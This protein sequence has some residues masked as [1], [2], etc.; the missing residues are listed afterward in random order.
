MF[1]LPIFFLPVIFSMGAYF[2]TLV[3]D[4]SLLSCCYNKTLVASNH[5]NYSDFKHTAVF[6][7]THVVKHS[8]DT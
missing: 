3:R 6:P 4:L 5:R 7:T 1:Y 8:R 2:D